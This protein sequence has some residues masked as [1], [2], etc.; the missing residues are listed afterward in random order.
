MSQLYDDNKESQYILKFVYNILNEVHIQLWFYIFDHQTHRLQ[1]DAQ[2]RWH[3]HYNADYNY[4]VFQFQ[5]GNYLKPVNQ[6]RENI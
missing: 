6:H 5:S 4:K 3:N 1:L 2:N